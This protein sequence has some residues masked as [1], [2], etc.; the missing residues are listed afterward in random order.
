MGATLYRVLVGQALIEANQRS[1]LKA[2]HTAGKPAESAAVATGVNHRVARVIDR[3]IACEPSQR[4]GPDDVLARIQPIRL[5]KLHHVAA[6][7]VQAGAIDDLIAR[8]E[9]ALGADHPDTKKARALQ[10]CGSLVDN[11]S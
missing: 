9:E 6:E 2:V 7:R 1:E 4:P 3:L 10:S 8:H 11:P 5:E